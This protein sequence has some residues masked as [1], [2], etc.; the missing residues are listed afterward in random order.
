MRARKIQIDASRLDILDVATLHSIFEA[1]TD[2]I[3]VLDLDGTLL[4]M[5]EG[6][7]FAMDLDAPTALV[8]RNWIDFWQGDDRDRAVESRGDGQV[9]G[10][11]PL[12][13]TSRHC[14]WCG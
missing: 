13:W 7:A 11:R 14:H 9:R 4:L 6:G 5:N 8:G 2:C 1:S 10:N 3:K 12:L